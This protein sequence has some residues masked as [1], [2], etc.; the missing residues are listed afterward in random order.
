MP[1]VLHATTLSVLV[2]HDSGDSQTYGF[3]DKPEYQPHVCEFSHVFEEA[4][5]ES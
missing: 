3:D 2:A 5:D 1:A 4:V